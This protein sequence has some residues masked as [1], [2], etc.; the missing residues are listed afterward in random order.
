[1]RSGTAC[2]GRPRLARSRP[3]RGACGAG[4][5]ELGCDLAVAAFGLHLF[6]A[7]KVEETSH[8]EISSIRSA[9]LQP[10]MAPPL[11]EVKGGK[12]LHFEEDDVLLCQLRHYPVNP[13][14]LIARICAAAT[15][16]RTGAYFPIKLSASS[17]GTMLPFTEPTTKA[18]VKPLSL[19]ASSASAA[20]WR[21]TKLP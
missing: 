1:M 10:R 8:G 20:S 6:A 17:A 4:P 19:M 5:C 9:L 18:S 13:Q 2:G 7:K 3:T 21:S 11:G 15:H 14:P 16:N 12:D